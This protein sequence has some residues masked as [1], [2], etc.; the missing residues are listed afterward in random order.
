[1][2]GSFS[3]KDIIL[4]K[5][6]KENSVVLVNEADYIKRMRE[7]FSDVSKFKEITV[8]PGKEINLIKCKLI[9][10]LKRVKSSATTDL[11]K[12][13]YPQGSQRGIMYRLSKIH[14][15]LVNQVFSENILSV[16][17]TLI[18]VVTLENK[19]GLV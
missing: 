11:Y 9:E 16:V 13:L 10:F 1:M 18:L 14:K 19:F 17:Y 3:N 2:K 6:D 15:R 4:Q 8:E 5:A 7:L 12:H